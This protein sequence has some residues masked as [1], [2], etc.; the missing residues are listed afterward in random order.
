M[1]YNSYLLMT[2]PAQIESLPLY[3]GSKL[4]KEIFAQDTDTNRCL[5]L[6]VYYRTDPPHKNGIEFNKSV[7]EFYKTALLESGWRME[8]GYLRLSHVYSKSSMNLQVGAINK[9]I[10]RI[11]VTFDFFPLFQPGCLP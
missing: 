2:I 3:P 11:L 8:P 9:K 6:M 1:T 10:Y 7:Q 5:V 4:E